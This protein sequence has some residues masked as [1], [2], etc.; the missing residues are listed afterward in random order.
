[1]RTEGKSPNGLLAF[2]NLEEL[3]TCLIF[4]QDSSIKE[5]DGK[6][7]TV[8]RPVTGAALGG[9][10]LLV[11]IGLISLPETEIYCRATGQI[12]KDRVK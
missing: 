6:N 2:L 5:A 7:L 4:D 11:N 12:L 1:L 8:R 10:L 9:N 3:N